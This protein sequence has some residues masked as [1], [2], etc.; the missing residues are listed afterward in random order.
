SADSGGTGVIAPPPAPAPTTTTT[1][2]TT[3]TTKATTTTPTTTTTKSTTTTPT[4][5]T[6]P[7][8][9][10]ATTTAPTT[11][12]TPT[13]TKATTTAPTTTTAPPPPADSAEFN[14]LATQ[15]QSISSTGYSSTNNLVQSQSPAVYDGLLFT[16]ND[17][18]LGSE[19]TF[20]KVFTVSA[21]PGSR[22]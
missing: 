6:A 13:T 12:T 15:L 18:T 19:S 1:A 14:G 5:T 17:F 21:E 7:T 10:K 22:A 16:N 4:T 3:T 11:T 2:L 20:G 9:T 8:T